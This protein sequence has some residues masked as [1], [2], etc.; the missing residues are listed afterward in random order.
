MLKKAVFL[1]QGLV[2]F[3]E[4]MRRNLESTHGLYH[5][6]AVLLAL[7]RNGISR[8]D[9][10]AAVQKVAM[11]CWEEERSF[12]ALVRDDAEITD[13][14]NAEQLDECFSLERHLGQVDM[15]FDRVLGE[16]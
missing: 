7:A 14:L 11:R 10:Y 6:G 8:E 2:V 3:P 1:M 13:W 9:A 4:R 12:E 16:G 15:L 5:S